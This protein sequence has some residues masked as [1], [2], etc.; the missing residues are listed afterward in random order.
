MKWY[1]GFVA[2]VALNKSTSLFGDTLIWLV[3]FDYF[4]GTTGSVWVFFVSAT[5]A[6]IIVE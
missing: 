4:S 2:Q 5:D 1:T 6:H 3:S